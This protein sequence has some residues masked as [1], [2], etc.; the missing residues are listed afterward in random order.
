M[1]G[2]VDVVG[3][4]GGHAAVGVGADGAGEHPG[5]AVSAET[6]GVSG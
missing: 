1:T 3:L 4:A 5:G 6:T 2:G